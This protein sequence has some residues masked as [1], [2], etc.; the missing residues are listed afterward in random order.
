MI[1]GRYQTLGFFLPVCQPATVLTST[2][3]ISAISCFE[4]PRSRRALRRWSPTVRSSVGYWRDGGFG[5]LTSRWQKPATGTPLRL[6]HLRSPLHRLSRRGMGAPCPRRPPA[7]RDADSGGSAGGA[8]VDHH[9][10]APRWVQAGV[11]RL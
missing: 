1:R 9:P 6:G 8:L 10:Q 5:T 3:S 11:P 4:S 7:V 2:P